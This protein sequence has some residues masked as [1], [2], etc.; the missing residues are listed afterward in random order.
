VWF[1]VTA[2]TLANAPD[3]APAAVIYAGA[4]RSAKARTT[5]RR[6]RVWLAELALIVVAVAV[7]W[8][9]FFAPDRSR[10]DDALAA[11]DAYTATM[12]P[13]LRQD[14]DVVRNQDAAYL[15]CSRRDTTQRGVDHLCLSVR[16]DRPEGRRVVGGYRVTTIGYDLPTGTKSRCFGIDAGEC[17]P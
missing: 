11:F 3:A 2:G 13:T 10:E 8:F 5:A 16:T 6:R 1:D 7:W 9:F 12:A 17:I 14:R 4:V 15:V